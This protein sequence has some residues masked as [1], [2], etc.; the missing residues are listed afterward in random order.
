MALDHASIEREDWARRY[1]A[2]TLPEPEE[3]RF[4]AHLVTCAQCQRDVADIENMRRGF[5][6]AARKGWLP[7]PRSEP[8]WLRPYAIAATVVVALLA[9]NLLRSRIDSG[10]PVSGDAVRDEMPGTRWVTLRASRASIPG[11]PDATLE[12]APDTT[13]VLLDVEIPRR[14]SDGSAAALCPDG[15]EPTFP[16]HPEY[17]LRL[18]TS[19]GKPGPKPDF[20]V[21]VGPQRAEAGRALV[22]ALPYG[23]LR[24]GP[25]DISVE[26]PSGSAWITIA[27]F[28]LQVR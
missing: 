14:C 10:G 28:R 22:F 7:M 15:G 23:R 8:R 20:P 19:E 5:A 21:L 16:A 6:E 18:A 12:R 2:R 4:E 13:I 3:A 9:V 17:R 25:L 27:S 26:A 1:A 11:S 24:A